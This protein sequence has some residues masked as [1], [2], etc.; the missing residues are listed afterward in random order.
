M[1]TQTYTQNNDAIVDDG[2]AKLYKSAGCCG[3]LSLE[4]GYSMGHYGVRNKSS[5]NEYQNQNFSLDTIDEMI[6]HTI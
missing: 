2:G 5:L 4:V 6:R 3:W 1:Y